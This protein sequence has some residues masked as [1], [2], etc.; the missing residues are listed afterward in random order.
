MSFHF[1]KLLAL[2]YASALLAL[3]FLVNLL[4]PT[5]A[6]ATVKRDRY[7]QVFNAICTTAG[8]KVIDSS[9]GASHS[10]SQ[11]NSVHC[12]LCVLGSAPP[13]PSSA[14]ASHDIFSDHGSM[15]WVFLDAPNRFLL[16]V[17]AFPRAPPN[18]MVSG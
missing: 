5:V 18:G 1:K 16:W 14:L 8:L 9:G 3:A 4:I 10:S 6:V 12:P 13:V 15:P 2:K 17:S 11:G 7:S